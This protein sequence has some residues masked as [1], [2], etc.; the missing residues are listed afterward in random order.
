[1]RKNENTNV[2]LAIQ[3][4][5]YA[6]EHIVLGSTQ[7]ENNNFSDNIRNILRMAVKDVR[8]LMDEETIDF[9]KLEPDENRRNFNLCMSLSSR[10]SLGNCTELAILALNYMIEHAPQI[11]A[12]IYDVIGGDHIFLVIGRKAQSCQK[13]PETWGDDAYICDPWSNKVYPAKEYRSK[14][15]NFYQSEGMNYTEDFNPAKHILTLSENFTNYALYPNGYIE[16]PIDS[17]I[18][19]YLKKIQAIVNTLT[20]L[21]NKFEIICNDIKSQYNEYDLKYLIV[22]Y[23]ITAIQKVIDKIENK[24][25]ETLLFQ[26]YSK[27]IVELNNKINGA[28][29]DVRELYFVSEADGTML[30][31][32]RNP[33]SSKTKA[34]RFFKQPPTTVKKLNSALNDTKKHLKLLK[35]AD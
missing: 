11:P 6:R 27:A 20:L 5:E 21:K 23:K 35:R 30:M 13:L 1:M 24:K 26:D 14:F 3:A 4:K 34:V 17:L 2:E 28:I 32:Y 25:T 33:E 19:N 22:K 31:Q 12:E 8:D 29:K 7:I 9:Y 16:T 18:K 15:K 10:Y